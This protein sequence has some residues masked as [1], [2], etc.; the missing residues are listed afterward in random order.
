MDRSVRDDERGLK[1]AGVC[2]RDFS[3]FWDMVQEFGGDRHALLRELAVDPSAYGNPDEIIPFRL[4]AKL[5]EIVAMRLNRP[6]FGL[7]LGAKAE[8][9]AMFGPLRVAMH[10]AGSLKQACE[11]Y[12]EFIRS[13]CPPFDSIIHYD[14]MANLASVGIDLVSHT[15]ANS[16]QGAENWLMLLYRLIRSITAD[17]IRP[18]EIWFR[19]ERVSS[20]EVYRRHFDENGAV[21]NADECDPLRSRGFRATARWKQPAAVRACNILCS[22]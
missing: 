5:F 2:A 12:E 6:S 11:F 22:S 16:V 20:V 4:T 9:L 1:E 7:D 13:Y 8:S 15:P 3:P 18:R 14:E 17:K 19:H 10:N 21:R